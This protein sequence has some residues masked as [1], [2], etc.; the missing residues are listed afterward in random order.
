MGDHVLGETQEP[1]SFKRC[2][3]AIENILKYPGVSSWMY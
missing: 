2:V 1:P 3:G